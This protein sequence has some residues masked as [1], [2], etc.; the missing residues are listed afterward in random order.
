MSM[1]AHIIIFL[2]GACGLHLPNRLDFRHACFM[3]RVSETLKNRIYEGW[4]LDQVP[5]RSDNCRFGRK[6]VGHGVWHLCFTSHKKIMMINWES[7]ENYFVFSIITVCG[8]RSIGLSDMA[9]Y[10]FWSQLRKH[11]TSLSQMERVALVKKINCFTETKTS[12][13]FVDCWVLL[14]HSFTNVW[15]FHLFVCQSPWLVLQHETD[16]AVWGFVCWLDRR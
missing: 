8:C 12:E 10:V 15:Q 14:A 16:S 4:H 7:F 11:I 6:H 3:S 2:P 1:G 9:A 13:L 5:I